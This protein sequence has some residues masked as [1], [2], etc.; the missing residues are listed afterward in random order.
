MGLQWTIKEIVTGLDL[1]EEKGN[2]QRLVMGS[3]KTANTQLDYF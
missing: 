2:G 3:Q 1:K